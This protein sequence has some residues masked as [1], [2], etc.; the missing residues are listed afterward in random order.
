MHITHMIRHTFFLPAALFAVTALGQTG[1]TVSDAEKLLQAVEGLAGDAARLSELGERL[2]NKP[3]TLGGDPWDAFIQALKSK[4]PGHAAT[5][6]AEAVEFFESKV[7]PVLAEH[8]FQ[9]HGPEEQKSDLRLDS[10]EAMQR[11]GQ[12]GPALVAGDSAKSLLI[13]AIEQSGDL[14]MPPKT[15]LPDEA[16]ANLKHWIDIGAPWPTG[17]APAVESMDERIARA[18][19][20]HWAF[21]PVVEPA[22]PEVR[23]TGW[24]ATPVDAFILNTLEA[25]G[26]EPS[27]PAD[28]YT[29][30]RRVTFDLTG[31]PPTPEEVD[32]FVSN[33]TPEAYKEVV[34]RL[35]ASPRYGERWGRYWLD[36]ARYADTRGYVF[37]NERTIPF[38][39]TYRDYVIRA[40]NE[41]LPY[42]QF[43][44][45]QLAADQLELGEDKRP[46]A[47][48][49]FLTLNRHFLGNIHDITDDRIDV[50]TRGLLGLTVSCARCHEHKYDPITMG[51]YYALYGVFRSS[52]EPPELPLIREPDPA[53]SQYQ[54]YLA[55]LNAAEDAEKAVVRDLHVQLL[56]H[57]REKLEAYLLAAHDTR[58]IADEEQFKT[59]AR[60]RGLRWQLV[61]R[62]RDFL[63]SKAQ[64]HD[65]VFGPWT[66]FA[67][68]TPESFA[69]Q[70]KNLAAAF[71]ENK[72][73]AKP[74]NKRIAALF[75][76]E[77]P[78]SMEDVAKRYTSALRAADHEWMNRLAA[79]AL[80][81]ASN[82]ALVEAASVA[83]PD[84]DDEELRQVLY[85]EG[86]PTNI[87]ESDILP[88]YDV[89]T[90]NRV[91]DTRNAVAR[92]KA[93][94]PGRP[95]R[96]MAL[97]DSAEPFEPHIFKRGNPQNKGETVPRRFLAVL[98][99]S[100]PPPF[101]KGSG[102]AEL[103]EA[104]ASEANPLTARV[105]VNRVWMNHFDRGLVDTPSDFGVRTPKP[106]HADL[107]DYLASQF[108]KQGW[109]TKTLHRLILLSSAYRQASVVS[110]AARDAD[111]ENR[112]ISRQNR[113]RLDFEALR[114]AVLAAAGTLDTT[115]GG[116]S[117]DIVN[118]PFT[119]RRT[120]YSFIERQN[121][122]GMFRTFDFANPDNH[123][124]RRF[125]TTVPQQALFMMNSPF[126]IEQAQQLAK[127]AEYGGTTGAVER[128]KAI[129]RLVYQR[130]PA[131]DE[132]AL[133]EK[134]IA[135]QTT[136][137]A[138][139][140]PA[141]QYGYGSVDETAGKVT[142]F[143]PFA[144]FAGADWRVGPEL[145]DPM[146]RYA[147]LRA[148]G[149]HPGP[150][151]A[152]AVIRR[153]V[154]PRDGKV[155]VRGT[156]KH[157]SE[158]SQGDGVTGFILSNAQG[159]VWKGVANKS[160]AAAEASLTVSAGDTVDFAVACGA[161][162]GWDSFV[163]APVVQY[164][165][166][167]SSSSLQTEWRADTD[168][169][170]PP[171]PAL[172]PWER[173]AQVLLASNEF[174][175][176][177]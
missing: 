29:L 144:Q 69:E 170:G 59:V 61:G 15:K 110:D 41:D 16:I 102:R 122:P 96:A 106:V 163:W 146:F 60:D 161:N 54:A 77:A 135:D 56:A 101:T 47:A 173:Y 176:V 38:S 143:I 84:P 40:F 149:G 17:T 126:V 52:V 44:K 63:K 36:V 75:A 139:P 79:D 136:L 71:A 125:R 100:D 168:F 124:P 67:A 7:R 116:P 10:R 19:R 129:Y 109:S 2:T 73:T 48:M 137:P 157:G 24:I 12:S 115:M 155:L 11:G 111:P 35:L 6:S 121:L 177:D 20:E 93:T 78:A 172:S 13:Q 105:W 103:A 55:D 18:R 25:A 162:D 145:P 92:V 89:P 158:E 46:L 72:D 27:P 169:G 164:E 8:C 133:A 3:L 98:S 34:D 30:V 132:C 159:L 113:R 99:A 165:V 4:N 81:K 53:D 118:P 39:Y 23:N 91:R 151:A 82:P 31:L 68:L 108:V 1:D 42:D 147:S 5:V 51:D 171:P 28:P 83:L 49:G 141:W 86:S 131:A 43:I 37:Q 150:D 140:A 127:R 85:G 58:E 57:A 117:V 104:I 154:A 76:G 32:A 21:Q 97:M 9:C 88:Y 134:F 65:R 167:E 22:V 128:A 130:E 80:R 119:T 74:V 33:P 114:D 50:V 95:D 64:A 153:W 152:S 45:H 142:K 66:A 120:V 138:P 107:L 87:A 26:L 160:E 112:L 175:F 148:N 14:K 174:A 90:Q 156:L 166:G 94:H 70:A 62:W 123:S